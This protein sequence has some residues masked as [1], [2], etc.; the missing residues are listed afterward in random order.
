[1]WEQFNFPELTPEEDAQLTIAL[2][3]STPQPTTSIETSTTVGHH[4]ATNNSSRMRSGVQGPAA[5]LEGS[6]EMRPP[7]YMSEVDGNNNLLPVNRIFLINN[8]SVIPISSTDRQFYV[9]VDGVYH[10]IRPM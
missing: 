6:S 10:V 5:Q 1:M 2:Q 7:P 3:G 9:V 4:E 8:D